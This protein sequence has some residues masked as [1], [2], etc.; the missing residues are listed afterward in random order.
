M[1]T[2]ERAAESFRALEEKFR[3]WKET[4]LSAGDIS[5][6]PMTAQLNALGDERLI[7]AYREAKAGQAAEQLLNVKGWIPMFS[8]VSGFCDGILRARGIDVKTIN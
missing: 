7:T 2:N 1:D 6:V 4:H 5:F 8:L 3:V